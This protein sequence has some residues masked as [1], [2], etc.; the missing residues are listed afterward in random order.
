MA[1][2]LLALPLPLAGAAGSGGAALG[3][4]ATRVFVEHF[5][6][7]WSPDGKRISGTSVTGGGALPALPPELSVAASCELRRRDGSRAG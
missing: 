7:S 5:E 6:P 4:V 2:A 1:L 3:P